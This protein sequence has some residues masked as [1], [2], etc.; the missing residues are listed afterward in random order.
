MK[1]Y[2][3]ATG[4][5]LLAGMVLVGCQ[6]NNNQNDTNNGTKKSSDNNQANQVKG[7]GFP[8]WGYDL[9]H[10]RHVPYK[11]ITKNNVKKM[12]IVWQQEI[13][14]WNKDVPNL[15]ED[16]PVVQNGVMY[17]TS[18]KN[19]VFAIDAKSGKKLWAWTP[20]KKV[21]DHIN[22][23]PWQSNVASRGV[24]V[25]NGNVYVLMID[26]RLAKL[27]AK[28]GKLI[29]MVNFWD[30]EPS[31]KLENRYYESSAPMYYDG[32]IY[33]GSSG[34]D[35]G[36]RGFVWAFKADTLEPLWK[37]PF[38]TVPERGKDWVKGKYTGGGSVWTPM[39]FDPDTDMMYFAVGNPAPDFYDE[40]RKGKNPYTDSI[41]ALDSKTGKF[42]WASSEVDHDVWDY[43]AAAT[44]MVLNA[45]VGGKKQKIV[46][47]GGKNGKWYAWDAKTGKTIYDG[48]PFVKIKHSKPSSDPNK[49]ELQWPG[50]PGG[51]SYAP[52]TYDPETN[53]VLIPGINSP[54]LMLSA[55]DRK[56]IA[57]DNN[58]FPGTKILPLPKDVVPSGNITAIDVNTGKKVYQVNT[59]D[60]MYGGFTSTASGLAFYGEM[61]GAVNALD[62]K[63]GK[64][65][66][67]MK[68]GGKA[69]KMAPSIYM[70]DGKQYVAV[71]T[72][73]TRVVV[74][75]LGGK[76]KIATP[77]K[78][79]KL[80]GEAD[81]T[82]KPEEVYKK[83]CISCHGDNLQGNTAPNLQ[84]VGKT[85]SKEEI[86]N[87]ILNGG[88]RMPAGLAK[89]AD[90]EALAE[91]LSKKK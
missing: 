78:N 83:S 61:D 37:E 63:K 8:N 72:G 75:G 64:V 74:Y 57:K 50:T 10:T 42:K 39:S 73:G 87:Q 34:G 15:Q 11:E 68:S 55:K 80:Q 60:P 90:A 27:D 6:S 29:K 33:V 66:W 89:G 51:E 54:N 35:N 9:Q 81:V 25:A 49:V 84:H 56:E 77:N 71:I 69:I 91:W 41:V 18:A 79:A 44:P 43:D 7:T 70:V 30:H 40:D 88:D 58:T 31:I 36:T 82:V 28:T 17:V 13:L 62:I 5:V 48:V 20:P 46:V 67:S 1:R 21:L 59:D 47:E 24:A 22:S 12:G 52:E 16:F 3:K 45:K 2:L 86:L 4:S 53:Y 23:L 19:H 26:N 14:E 32:N 76:E 85:M 38:W 65:L